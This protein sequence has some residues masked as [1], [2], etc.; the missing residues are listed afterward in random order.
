MTNPLPVFVEVILPLAL[1]WGAGFLARRL[2]RVDPRPF[3]RV[4]L[5]LLTPSL[6]FT[7]LMESDLAAGTAG[8][9]ALVVLLLALLLGL[10][11]LG[12]TWLLRLGPEERSAFLLP[13]IFVNAVNYGFPVTLLA[14]GESG[15]QWAVVFAICHAT[16][17]NTAGAYIAVQGQAGG[18]GRTLRRVSRIPMIYAVLLALIFRA[19]HVFF[20]GTVSLWGLEIA[21]LPSLYGAIQRLAQAAIPTFLL[22]LGMQLGNQGREQP[23]APHPFD[24]SLVLLSLTRLVI[25]PALAWGLTLLVGLE[26]IAARVTILEAAMPSAVLTVILATEF[27]T[28]PRFVARAVVVTTLLSML[29]LTILLSLWG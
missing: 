9:I 20:T 3:S 24:P 8:R 14:L 11:S 5:Y 15:L 7:K 28:R 22:V 25:S 4:G 10:L 21:L 18:L 2:L 16:L 12:L 17:S 19:T 23:S 26:G 13:T 1:V 6:I 27:Q 29:T